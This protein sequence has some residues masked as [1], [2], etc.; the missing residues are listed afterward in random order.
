VVR[1]VQD[2]KRKMRA[3]KKG[4]EEEERRFARMAE[5]C[6]LGSSTPATA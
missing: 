2:G 6:R 3:V 5:G 4:E 1:N